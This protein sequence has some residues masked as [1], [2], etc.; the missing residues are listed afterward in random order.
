MVSELSFLPKISK[1]SFISR[2]QCGEYTEKETENLH[3]HTLQACNVGDPEMGK[4][5]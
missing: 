1:L 5:N 2:T 3:T 4:V